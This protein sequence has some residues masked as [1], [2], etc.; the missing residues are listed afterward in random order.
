M[1]LLMIVS[2]LTAIPLLI[3]NS[4]QQEKRCY[5][6]I[7]LLGR[8]CVIASGHKKGITA[9][10]KESAAQVLQTKDMKFRRSESELIE[11]ST[12]MVKEEN[13]PMI[14]S[15]NSVSLERLSGRKS[16]FTS[17]NQNSHSPNEKKRQKSLFLYSGSTKKSKAPTT[18]NL[19][20]STQQQCNSGC[21]NAPS[22]SD[23][24]RSFRENGAHFISS[25]YL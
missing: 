16:K 24:L 20:N 7:R 15:K 6:D 1:I 19:A 2:K 4:I 10:E 21:D 22:I 23:F 5:T 11:K 14:P 9:F 12:T 13:K 18:A 17:K 8:I 3:S 25:A